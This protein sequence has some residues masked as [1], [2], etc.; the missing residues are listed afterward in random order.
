M[1]GG[2]EEFIVISGLLLMFLEDRRLL[3]DDAWF[4]LLYCGGSKNCFQAMFR[5]VL[6]ADVQEQ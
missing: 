6:Q 1:I 5:F 4:I 2:G 3:R